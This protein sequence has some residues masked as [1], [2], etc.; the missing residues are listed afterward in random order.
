[1]RNNN[2]SIAVLERIRNTCSRL[3]I[4]YSIFE[5]T[6]ESTN[7]T[8]VDILTR[9]VNISNSLT[10]PAYDNIDELRLSDWLNRISYIK[11]YNS[12]PSNQKALVMSVLKY[13]QMANDNVKFRE[14]FELIILEAVGTCGDRMALSILRLN[15]ISKLCETTNPEERNNILIHGVWTLSLLEEIARTKVST[16][17]FVDEIEIYLAYPI[18]LHERLKIPIEINDMLYFSISGVNDV[19][20]DFAEDYVKTT[21]NNKELREE[22]LESQK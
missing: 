18:K 11:N 6:K 14:Q 16:L 2:F 3:S 1:L 20:L 19:D 5:Q 13:I 12:S 17:R 9:F 7:Q 4:E 8:V 15:I 10:I 21:I 22:F